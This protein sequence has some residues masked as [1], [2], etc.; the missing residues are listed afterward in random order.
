MMD[1]LIE[2]KAVGGIKYK[3]IA[4]GG[5]LALL[6]LSLLNSAYSTVLD[7]IKEELSLSYTLS[8]ALM[9]AYF[10]GYTLGQI[11]WGILADRYGSSK[12]MT[13]SIL[14]ISLSTLLF[15]FSVNP[16]MIVG[17]RFCAGLLGAGVF[18]P[19]VRLVSGWYSSNQRGTV[20]GLLGVGGSLGL[21]ISSWATP[22]F[23][24]YANWRVTLAGLSL[25]GLIVAGVMSQTLRDPD[26][27]SAR[28]SFTNVTEPM[29][30]RAFWF[31]SLGQFIRLGS[32]YTFIA[33]LPLVLKE[34]YGF[35]ILTTGLAMALFNTS[36][37]FANPLGGIISDR[38]GAKMV[39]GISFGV[40]GLSV[41]GLTGF[42]EGILIYLVVVILGWFIN[43]VRSPAFAIIP[44][45]Y[46]VEASGGI[47]GIQNTFASMGALILPLFLGYVKDSTSSYN[48]G[49]I[50]LSTLTLTG[51]IL[52]LTIKNVESRE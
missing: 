52:I 6:T 8:G 46:G 9:S 18:V 25:F 22:L 38:V 27:I 21:V 37:M 48:I 40:L 19:N 13:I 42:L 33:W 4:L 41:W 7:I 14:G 17:A 23:T 35:K 28:R 12:V 49:W 43:F 20:L 1:W 50:A 34:E 26:T 5:F 16:W 2:M 36:G 24:L 32:Y 47:S 31:L 3:L 29:K 45:L 11:P 10:V 44:K 15:S 51:A 30:T 39:L